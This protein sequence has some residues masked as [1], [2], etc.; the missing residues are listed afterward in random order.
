MAKNISTIDKY[1][2]TRTELKS[3]FKKAMN[4]E[5][6]FFRLNMCCKQQW[7]FKGKKVARARASTARHV[8]NLCAD[9]LCIPTFWLHMV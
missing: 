5:I 4:D 1:E 7:L 3:N 8:E 9:A 6:L 2:P